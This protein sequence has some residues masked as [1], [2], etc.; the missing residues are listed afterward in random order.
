MEELHA[1][2]RLDV[3]GIERPHALQL[4]WFVVIPSV[5]LFA[6]MT[7][8]YAGSDIREL[9]VRAFQR[10]WNQNHPNEQLKEDGIYG[11]A[12]EKA[13]LEYVFALI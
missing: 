7:E 8:A 9:S 13:I 6:S 5:F 4:C 3:A 10:L 11:P 2:Q 12:T 1:E